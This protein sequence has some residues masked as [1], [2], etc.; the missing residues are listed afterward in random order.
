MRGASSVAALTGAGVS[1]E[2][3]VP[4]FRG[5]GGLWNN[6]RA[7]DLATPEAFARDPRL[8]WEWYDWR[9]QIIAGA[10]PNPGHFALAKLE[11]QTPRFTLITQNVDG[12][13]DRAGSSRIL[14]IHGD[15]WIVRCVDCGSEHADLRAPLP[16]LPT[17]CSCGGRLRPGVVWF[18][19][20]LPQDV[21]RKAEQAARSAEVFLVV[22][23]SALVFP[24]AS[25]IELAKSSGAKVI[26]INLAASAVSHTVD[27]F[28]QGLSGELSP[29]LIA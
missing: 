9:R 7:E 8:V 29:Q 14:K 17:R 13:H 10:Q 6:F 23:T 16:E 19:E 12:L 3:N 18:G 22:G 15:I 21:W 25:L 28:L 4:T 24:A 26:E 20:A 5:N 27:Q 11:S 1:A 2:S